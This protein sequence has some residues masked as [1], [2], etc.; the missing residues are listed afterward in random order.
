MNK[1]YNH[2]CIKFNNNSSLYD[3]KYLF[4]MSSC[5]FVYTYYIL[6]VIASDKSSRNVYMFFYLP[7]H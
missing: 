7:F 5:N 1:S 3:I 4:C 6:R 2:K